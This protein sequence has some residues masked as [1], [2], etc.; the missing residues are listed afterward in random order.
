LRVAGFAFCLVAPLAAPAS[1]AEPLRTM[2]VDYYHTGTAASETF[3][4]DRVVVE[5]A[6]WP[7]NP[8]R[9]IDDTN[10]GK[11]FLEVID[12]ATNRVVYSRGPSR[13]RCGF[14]SP[15]TPSRWW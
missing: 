7:G 2:R 4:I 1:A 6:P 11:Y 9:A 12:T 5:P 13:N 14:R 10:L 15:S 3:A 8:S